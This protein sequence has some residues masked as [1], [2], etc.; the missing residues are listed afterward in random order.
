MF[1]SAALE[2]NYLSLPKNI[3]KIVISWTATSRHV[4]SLECCIRMQTSKHNARLS[5]CCSQRR[6]HDPETTIRLSTQLAWVSSCTGCFQGRRKP[7]PETTLRMSTHTARLSVKS[8]R[9][10]SRLTGVAGCFYER[11]H[12]HKK[13]MFEWKVMS[14]IFLAGV[15]CIWIAAQRSGPSQLPAGEG[16]QDHRHDLHARCPQTSR[17][18]Q[19]RISGRSRSLHYVC[20]CLCK[21]LN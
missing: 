10:F 4:V 16:S 12:D 18:G 14:V 2:Q 17:P 1:C 15:P 11:H 8:Y 21:T 6:K 5:G 19:C 9:L 3:W 20:F 7:D 13:Y